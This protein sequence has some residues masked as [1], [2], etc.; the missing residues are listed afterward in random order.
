MT[1]QQET[2]ADTTAAIAPAEIPSVGETP[3]EEAEKVEEQT[4]A[5][6]STNNEAPE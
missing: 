5:E 4:T 2:T 6:E 3:K 1:D